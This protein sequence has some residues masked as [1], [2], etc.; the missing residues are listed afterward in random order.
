M[1]CPMWT[2][3]FYPGERATFGDYKEAVRACMIEVLENAGYPLEESEY[4]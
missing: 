3:G 2:S 1:T 4:E